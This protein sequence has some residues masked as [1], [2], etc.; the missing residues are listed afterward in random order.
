MTDYQDDL[1]APA[2]PARSKKETAKLAAGA[3]LLVLLVLFVVAN[4][5]K[6]EIDFLVAEV[7]LPLVIV[8]LVTAVIGGAITELLRF[9]RNRRK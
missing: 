6:T 8:L 3:V 2:H 5:R 9:A 7:D 4:T 1:T